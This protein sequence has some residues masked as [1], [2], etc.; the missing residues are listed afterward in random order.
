MRAPWHEATA[1]QRPNETCRT[2]VPRTSGTATNETTRR[3]LRTTPQPTGG[4]HGQEGP[5]R[6]RYC[7]S[8]CP[9]AERCFRT[10]RLSRRICRRRM[11]RRWMG[12]RLGLARTGCRYWP[13]PRARQCGSLGT[14][15]G[16]GCSGLE[17]CWVGWL[18][19]MASGLDWLG[20]ARRPRERLLVRCRVIGGGPGGFTASRLSG[21][22]T[23]SSRCR[24]AAFALR[25]SRRLSM[26][27]SYANC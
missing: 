19:E 11:A 22:R 6:A 12:R 3:L 10:A 20:L 1:L 23:A 27:L 14:W 7:R 4:F 25:Q 2:A 18:Y 24:T 26:R 13:R 16:L 5:F 17:L 21:S 15:L 9:R 8:P